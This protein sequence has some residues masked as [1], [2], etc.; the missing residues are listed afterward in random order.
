VRSRL[1]LCKQE[2]KHAAPSS[3]SKDWNQ[4]NV[5]WLFIMVIKFQ[6]KRIHFKDVLKH[7]KSRVNEER[8]WV[9]VLYR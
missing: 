4:D 2:T 1:V 8:E 9:I 5:I 3:K 6:F 7:L